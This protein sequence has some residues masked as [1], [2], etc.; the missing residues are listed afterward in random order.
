MYVTVKLDSKW[1]S[2]CNLVV[3]VSR[4]YSSFLSSPVGEGVFVWN[5]TQ[6]YWNFSK[7]V[8]AIEDAQFFER[9]RACFSKI[10]K[11]LLYY[12]GKRPQ[13]KDIGERWQ[14]TCI[15]EANSTKKLLCRRT[16]TKKTYCRDWII[17]FLI[18]KDF[19]LYSFFVH[20]FVLHEKDAQK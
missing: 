1:K 14:K 16:T 9:T 12:R 3:D 18:N 19:P 17:L 6:C 13:K 4:N 7:C 5:V 10:C 2:L 11:A 20:V 8:F 15:I